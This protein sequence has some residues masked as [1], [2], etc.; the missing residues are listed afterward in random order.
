MVLHVLLWQLDADGEDTDS[1]YNTG[2]LERD[3]IRDLILTVSPM[4]R[5]E[6]V[7]AIRSCSEE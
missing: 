7:R 2:E 6:Y 3:L 4:S 5:I 1:E